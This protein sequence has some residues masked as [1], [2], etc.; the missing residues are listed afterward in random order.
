[1]W[2]GG[3]LASNGAEVARKKICLPKKEGG[4]GVKNLEVWNQVAIVKHLW[5]IYTRL[6]N[7][8]WSSWTHS[9]FLCGC[10]F[11]EVPCPK[12]FS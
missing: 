6:G 10:N 3:Q 8:I 2:N 4:L 7:F 12:H 5:V 9:C 11:W 1:L